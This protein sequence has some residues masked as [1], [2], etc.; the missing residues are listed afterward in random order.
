MADRYAT[1]AFVGFSE[2]E[3]GV[4]GKG[5]KSQTVS[6]GDNPDFIYPEKVLRNAVTGTTQP[7]RR[8]YMR[9]L[10][11]GFEG[12]TSLSRKRLHFQFNPDILV[13][14]VNARNDIQLWMNQDPVQLMQPIPG[15]ANFSFEL[16]FNREAEVSTAQYLA[17]GALQSSTKKANLPL[18]GAGRKNDPKSVN[19]PHSAVTDIGVLA[20]LMVFDEI[21]GQGINTQLIDKV[22][23]NAQGI[24]AAERN[25][26]YKGS[27]ST[28]PKKPAQAKV[29]T[30]NSTGGIT[31]IDVTSGGKGYVLSPDITIKAKKANASGA[32]LKAT[33]AGGKVT[34]VLIQTAGT[35]YQVGDGLTFTGGGSSTS[36]SSDS[37]SDAED[38]PPIEF[39]A[40]DAK[41]IIYN[42]YGNSAFLVSLPVR[43]VFSSLFMVEGYITSTIV[44]FN[45]FNASMVPTQCSVGVTMQALYIGFARRDTFLTTTLETALKEAKKAIREAEGSTTTTSEVLAA[46][47]AGKKAFW[48]IQKWGGG[49]RNFIPGEDSYTSHFHVRQFFK[50]QDG[51]SSEAKIGFQIDPTKSF[52]EQCKTDRIIGVTATATWT[53]VYKGNSNSSTQASYLAQDENTRFDV[54]EV[55]FELSASTDMNKG[56]LASGGDSIKF[57]FV[58]DGD[59]FYKIPD[60]TATSKYDTTFT[61]TFTMKT[62]SASTPAEQYLEAVQKGKHYNETFEVRD[63]YKFYPTAQRAD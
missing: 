63:S 21:I 54:D 13:R 48:R 41:S 56:D 5:I 9:M 37:T 35:N 3:S 20:D 55:I 29:K 6:G 38:K 31:A 44:T 7:M 40:S 16:L 12:G 4:F 62:K 2:Y 32:V 42:N 11:Q 58:F 23:K 26:Y 53:C 27:Q 36:A 25:A 49:N 10:S 39:D 52:Q 45:K 59:N 22:I 33:V 17:G 57:E 46:K 47:A 60:K 14:N 43:I 34:E 61:V 51:N 8:G 30:V 28:D 18:Q 1:N 50:D 15:D 19:I 24:N